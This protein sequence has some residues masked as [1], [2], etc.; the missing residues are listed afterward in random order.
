MGVISEILVKATNS[1]IFQR[2]IT[3]L[4]FTQLLQNLACESQLSLPSIFVLCHIF[5]NGR[6]RRYKFIVK[7]MAAILDFKKIAA[8][9]KCPPVRILKP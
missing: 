3:L 1:Y 6:I 2:A 4:I 7:K 5:K 9:M 8:D